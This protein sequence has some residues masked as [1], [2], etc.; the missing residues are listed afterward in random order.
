MVQVQRLSRVFM[1]DGRFQNPAACPCT[2]EIRNP[3][4]RFRVFS[5]QRGR[6]DWRYLTSRH[7]RYSWAKS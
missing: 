4:L 7:S 5:S 6:R 1:A 2:E 3:G